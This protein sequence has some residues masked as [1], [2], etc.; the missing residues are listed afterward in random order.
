MSSLN[1]VDLI[2]RLGRD[3][4]VRSLGNGDKVA[5]LRIATSERWKDKQTGERKEK[6]EWHSVT[7]WGGLVQVVESYLRKGSNVYVSGK[8]ETRKWQDQQG[9]DRYTTEVVLRGPG[10]VM[11]MLDG[12]SGGGDD[13][14]RRGVE[15]K[16][17]APANDIPDDEIPF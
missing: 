2:G 11:Q 16:P 8:L 6:T 12:P 15:Y 13:D 17:N 5:N 4:E 10:A 7:I 9:N 14:Q 1:R 3:P